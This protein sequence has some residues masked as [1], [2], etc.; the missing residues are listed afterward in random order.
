MKNVFFLI[1]LLQKNKKLEANLKQKTKLRNRRYFRTR[2][3]WKMK[4]ANLQNPIQPRIRNQC[5]HLNTVS[6]FNFL[7]QYNQSKQKN[8]NKRKASISIS[9]EEIKSIGD[10]KFMHTETDTG[11]IEIC[12]HHCFRRTNYKSIEQKFTN[13]EAVLTWALE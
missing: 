2:K 9:R 11:S 3:S 4:E 13:W 8:K 12:H 5:Q 1:L 7:H 6:N 10:W